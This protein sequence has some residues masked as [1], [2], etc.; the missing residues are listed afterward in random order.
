M[1]KPMAAPA[2]AIAQV[3][4]PRVENSWR[5]RELKIMVKLNEISQV[6][7]TEDLQWWRASPDA[8]N[9]R[10]K[11]GRIV[12]TDTEG[13]KVDANTDGMGDP[14]LHACLLPLIS[15]LLLLPKIVHQVGTLVEHIKTVEGVEA[16]SCSQNVGD[17]VSRV[18]LSK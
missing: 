2:A 13:H 3:L 12:K 16:K 18:H 4:K 15:A 6:Q 1:P 11:H 14:K 7:V 5:L 8:S 9:F 17:S 10:S